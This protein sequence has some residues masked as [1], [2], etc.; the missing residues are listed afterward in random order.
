MGIFSVVLGWGFFHHV[1]SLSAELQTQ[2]TPDFFFFYFKMN[3][4]V[5]EVLPCTPWV[6]GDVSPYL[7]STVD[8]AV[9]SLPQP[10]LPLHPVAK[11]LPPIL[12]LG[13]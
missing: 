7:T 6:L 12:G 2:F 5:C 10:L 3:Y 8:L 9:S 4:N 1:S 11:P 13:N